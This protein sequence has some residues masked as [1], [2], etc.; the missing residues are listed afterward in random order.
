MAMQLIA[1]TVPSIAQ[2]HS[3]QNAVQVAMPEASQPMPNLHYSR[4][5]L[6]AKVANNLSTTNP[7]L[8]PTGALQQGLPSELPADLQAGLEQ[9]SGY[10]MAQVAVHYNSPKPAQLQAHAYA[11]QNEIHLA[12]GQERHLPHEAW[13]LVQQAQG[14]VTAQRQMKDIAVNDDTAL[15]LEADSMGAQA[16]A[17]GRRA[18]VPAQRR[19]LVGTRTL[20]RMP[21]QRAVAQLGKRWDDKKAKKSDRVGGIIKVVDSKLRERV[22]NRLRRSHLRNLK[23][24]AKPRSQRFIHKRQKLF[25]RGYHAADISRLVGSSDTT[26]SLFNPNL[27][28]KI[29]PRYSQLDVG[30]ARGY[31]RPGFGGQPFLYLQSDKYADKMIPSNYD[32]VIKE[33]AGNDQQIAMDILGNIEAGTDLGTDRRGQA[34][35]LIVLLTQFIE[36]HSSRLPGAD[37]LAR[38]LLRRIALGQLTFQQAFNRKNGLFI[39]AWAKAGGAPRGGQMAARSLFGTKKTSDNFDFAQLEE[40]MGEDA[41]EQLYETIDGYYSDDSDSED[42][43]DDD[44]DFFDERL[45]SPKPLLEA[46]NNALQTLGLDERLKDLRQIPLLAN[47][48]SKIK[49]QYLKQAFVHHPD[50]GGDRGMFSQMG[51]ARDHLVA[52]IGKIDDRGKIDLNAVNLQQNLSREGLAQVQVLGDGNCFYAAVLDQLAQAGG[53]GGVDPLVL[54]TRLAQL[55]LDNQDEV[56]VFLVGAPLNQVLDDILTSRRWNNMGGDFAPQLMA[57]VLQRQI[58]VIQPSG[59]LTFDPNPTL[60]INPGNIYGPGGGPITIMYDGVGHYDSTRNVRLQLM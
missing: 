36:A 22:L 1:K 58:R 12:P 38:A 60:N 27:N 17:R 48:L 30:D 53:G 51:D 26:L 4:S 40:Y 29:D 21:R 57:S 41:M 3:Q 34:K 7:T 45:E 15:E 39:S 28:P 46:I 44:D 56:G 50:K 9:M 19:K 43:D 2:P 14:R 52:L 32:E 47:L 10:S 49:K 16:L 54:R 37:K 6:Q 25:N 18:G 24:K 59:V 13:H 8:S 5:P 35:A 11:R 42:G 31:F 23:G 33:F 55:I 20:Q